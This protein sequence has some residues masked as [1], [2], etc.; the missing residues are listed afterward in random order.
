MAIPFLRS[1]PSPFRSAKNRSSMIRVSTLLAAVAL[2]APAT[3]D[4]PPT[5]GERV[6]RHFAEAGESGFKGCF[7]VADLDG[8]T[9]FRSGEGCA[10]RFPPCST[11]KIPNSLISLQEGAIT[12]ETVL[13]WD[14]SEQY[15]KVWERDHDLASAMRSSVVWF[16]QE[17]AR[18]VG[19]TA[20]QKHVDH[21]EYGNRDLRG[22]IDR[23]WLGRSLNISADEQIVFLSR[24]WK[25]ELDIDAEHVATVKRIL[26]HDE[27]DDWQ[28]RAKTGS[29]RLQDT[30][31]GWWVGHVR[32][33]DTERLFA[34]RVIGAGA[35]G[36]E[37]RRLTRA[38]LADE[39]VANG[40]G[41]SRAI[42]GKAP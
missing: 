19:E 21:F 25:G 2:A 37:A 7:L 18:R 29:C 42:P 23:F 35:E 33:G 38:L 36:L 24:M 17:L 27:A 40:I 5:L 13:E 4:A 41:L 26:L 34:T 9:V 3:A 28:L 16:Y 32:Q 12:P 15:Y 8:K 14:G 31:L 20:M 6:D 10:E 1:T 30:T 11:F 39:A 22:G